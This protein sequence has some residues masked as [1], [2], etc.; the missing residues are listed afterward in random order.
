MNE[1]FSRWPS[2]S[3][4]DLVNIQSGLGKLKPYSN[5]QIM[6]LTSSVI[7]CSVRFGSA[8]FN[9]FE[10]MG[11]NDRYIAH[12]G[13]GSFKRLPEHDISF[14]VNGQVN[15]FDKQE[16]TLWYFQVGTPHSF[17]KASDPRISDLLNICAL[18]FSRNKCYWGFN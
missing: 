10:S 8:V 3:A 14:I 2:Y 18:F 7:G 4:F 5:E 6:D 12:E 11:D 1:K 13:D 16:S 15:I 9:L 17:S